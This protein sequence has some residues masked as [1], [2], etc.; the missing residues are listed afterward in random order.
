MHKLPNAV[1][2]EESNDPMN[3]YLK[4]ASERGDI[5]GEQPIKPNSI[6]DLINPSDKQ[7][8]LDKKQ[9]QQIKEEKAKHESNENIKINKA[10]RYA[11]FIVNTKNNIQGIPIFI[12]NLIHFVS[13][14]IDFF[15]YRSIWIVR[16]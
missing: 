16:Y 1:N 11:N 4:S 8:L 6:F 13:N 10:Q 7:F 2:I 14:C 5:L 3:N 15:K 12:L 9:Q